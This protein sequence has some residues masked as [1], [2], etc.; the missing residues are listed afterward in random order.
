MQ[1]LFVPCEFF[2]W[3]QNLMVHLSPIR[4]VLLVMVSFK[5]R[6]LAVMRLLA[7]WSNLLLFALFWGLLSKSWSIHQLDVKNAFLHGHLNETVY[8]HQLLGFDDH[9]RPDNVF[10]LQK[11]LYVPKKDPQAWYQRFA[12]FVTTINFRNSIFDFSL[13]FY[14]FKP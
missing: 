5:E 12:D 8:M 14:F 7:L 9:A 10:L 1:M 4:R 13:F 2:E 6:A 11:S 3:K